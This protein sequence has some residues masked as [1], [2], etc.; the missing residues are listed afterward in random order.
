MRRRPC[1]LHPV[2]GPAPTADVLIMMRGGWTATACIWCTLSVLAGMRPGVFY[3]PL[4]ESVQ[5]IQKGEQP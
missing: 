3:A 4:L 2:V 5:M 1:H